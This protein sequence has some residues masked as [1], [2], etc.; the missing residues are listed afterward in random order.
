MMNP[1]YFTIH[2]EGTGLQSPTADYNSASVPAGQQW[3]MQ[4]KETW[5]DREVRDIATL[6]QG[7]REVPV[8][9]QR[10]TLIRRFLE[11]GGDDLLYLADEVCA[12]GSL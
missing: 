12:S 5:D 3:G 2:T 6:L 1:D 9:S 10:I 11:Q 8:D 7:L 4:D